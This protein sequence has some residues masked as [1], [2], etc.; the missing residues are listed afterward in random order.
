MLRQSLEAAGHT[1]I[2]A[3]DGLQGL[4]TARSSRPDVVILDVMMPFLNG[5][6]VAA[7]MKNDPDLLAIPILMLTVVDD[8]QRA[9]G[10]G[11]ERYLNK[12][13]EPQKIVA[14]INSLLDTHKE[15]ANAFLVG[16]LPHLEEP[17]LDAMKRSKMQIHRVN[18]PAELK[19][20]VELHPPRIVIVFGDE[21]DESHK[22]GEIQAALGTRAALTRFVATGDG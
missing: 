16:E 22:R 14:E 17:L 4:S 5:F 9:Y 3:E 19:D 20:A 21:Y 6:D 18:S 7:S 2:E 1:V 15:P 12:P 8:A 10:L 13:F 11:V